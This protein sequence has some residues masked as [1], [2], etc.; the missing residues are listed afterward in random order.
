MC[1]NRVEVNWC[2]DEKQQKN[3]VMQCKIEEEKRRG[4]V[5]DFDQREE[6]KEEETSE[7]V[8]LL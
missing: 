2:F 5:V 1:V 6:E 7:E 3:K 8:Q 4:D